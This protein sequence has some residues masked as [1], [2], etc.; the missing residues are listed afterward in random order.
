MQDAPHPEIGKTDT[1]GYDVCQFVLD[2]YKCVSLYSPQKYVLDEVSYA[3][4]L[5]KANYSIDYFTIRFFHI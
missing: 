3:P 5:S 1:P 4:L 2:A